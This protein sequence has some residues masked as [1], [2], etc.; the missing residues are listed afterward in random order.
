MP[1]RL[2][3]RHGVRLVFG[4]AIATFSLAGAIACGHTATSPTPAAADVPLSAPRGAFTLSG[5]VQEVAP[6]EHVL[7]G[8]RVDIITGPDAGRFAVSD[9]SGHYALTG[10]SAG[11]AALVTTLDGFEPFR[12]GVSIVG[13]M[14][15]DGWLT[16]VPPTNASGATATARCKDGTWS[17]SQSQ[18]AA[19]T[20]NGGMAYPV[21]PGP[22]CRDLTASVGR[23]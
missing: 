18:A 4:N 6:N 9:G 13:N 20:D 2:A 17:W 10:V 19:C 22:F 15:A 14:Q 8:A 23:K 11:S 12:F 21:C 5:T 1:A 7:P 16:P 3:S